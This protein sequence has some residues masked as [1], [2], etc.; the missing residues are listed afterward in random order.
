LGQQVCLQSKVVFVLDEAQEFVPYDK[1][2]EDGTG[3]YNRA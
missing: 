3:F 1:K 2:K